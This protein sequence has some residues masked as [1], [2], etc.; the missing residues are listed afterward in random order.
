MLAETS[1][2]ATAAD[3]AARAKDDAALAAILENAGGWRLIPQGQQA[4]VQRA[5]EKL[6]DACILAHPRL[7]LARV[8]LGIK[9]DDT[10]AARADYDRLVAAASQTDLPGDLW[11]EIRVVGDI[12]ADYENAP[13]T[14]DGLL[15]REALLRTLPANDHLILANAS[16]TLSARYFESGWLDHALEPM[17]AAR[18]HYRTLGLL[19]S[20]LFTRLF[21]ARVRWAQGVHKDAAAILASAHAEIADIVGDRVDLAAN[22]A[23]FDAVLLYEQ[24]RP[25]DALAQLDW[26]LPYME[27]S[28]GWVDVFAA[29]YFTAARALVA[30][31]AIEDAQAMIARARSRAERRLLPELEQL[32]SLC[33]LELYLH[34]DQDAARARDYADEIGLDALADAVGEGASVWRTVVTAAQLCRAKLA[35]LE[36]R[37]EAA[38]AGL[39]NL[40]HWAGQHG[41]GRLLI[42]V[43]LLLACGLREAGAADEAETCFD[44]AVGR[45][46]FQGI[47]RPFIDAWRFVEP[48][49]KERL[50]AAAQMD[51]FRAQFLTTLAR[52]LS[53]RPP[54]TPVQSLLSDAEATIL[55]HLSLG[56][57][58]KEIARLIGKSPDTVKYR[59]KSVFRKIGVHKRRDAV[60]VLRERGLIAERDR[61]AAR[62]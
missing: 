47:V 32:A 16:E 20:D 48:S 8:Y 55:E 27:Q 17:L 31:G 3:R 25:A 7:A 21:E 26:A 36:G 33:E 43:N 58:N 10:C 12:L 19:D 52:S 39:R 38:I 4:V 14:L 53:T 56:Y 40:K 61:A 18:E 42:D 57:S 23:A 51:R 41:A 46:M 34:H 29:A 45:A 54:G 5:L 15:Q 22:C 49:L 59:L 28:D 62:G 35:L 9:S 60:R 1:N 24:D 11:T 50:K 44:E 37:H 13:V 6:P 2:V 30:Q